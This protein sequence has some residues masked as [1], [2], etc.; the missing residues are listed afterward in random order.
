M[1]HKKEQ[2]PYKVEE[3]DIFTEFELYDP[4]FDLTKYNKAVEKILN[5]DLT[6][7]LKDEKK[8]LI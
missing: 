2:S 8:K 6:E 1:Y 4:E 7:K 5:K 3:E